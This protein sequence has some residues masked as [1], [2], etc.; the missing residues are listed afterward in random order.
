[1]KQTI[2]SVYLYM[3]KRT[4]LLF[5][6]FIHITNKYMLAL[7]THPFHPSCIALESTHR[8]YPGFQP[9]VGKWSSH[10]ATE[11]KYL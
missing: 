10:V 8:V 11:A 1:M 3:T 7:N 6:Q 9:E 2:G 4:Y 5:N